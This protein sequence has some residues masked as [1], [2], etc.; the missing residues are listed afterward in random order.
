MNIN[1]RI[2]YFDKVKIYSI[3]ATSRSGSDYL[4]SLFDD[5]PQ[6]L[7]FNGSLPLYSQF[8]NKI[9]F[10]D[11]SNKNIKLTIT[12]FI[13][14]FFFLLNTKFDKEEGKNTLGEKK[15]KSIQIS[16]HKF[17]KILFYFINKKSFTKKNFYLGI[18]FA[19][20]VCIH[21]NFS[22]IKVLL[23]HPH[24]LEE[25]KLFK[26]DFKDCFYLVTIRH[27]VA[28]YYSTIYNLS[29]HNPKKFSNIKHSFI[30]F[31]R[32]F[33]DSDIFEKYKLKY[34]CIRLEDLPH[35]KTINA[36]CKIMK[37]KFSVKL[38]KPTFAGLKWNG[39]KKQTRDYNDKWSKDRTYNFWREK[40]SPRDQFFLNFFFYK[41][42]KHY[43]YSFYKLN[44]K[45]IF[46]F[47]FL[48]LMPT[49]FEK[50]FLNLK[51]F[52]LNI[53][54]KN[55]IKK[56]IEFLYDYT[57]YFRRILVC[58]SIYLKFFTKHKNKFLFIK[59]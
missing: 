23:L 42:L 29:K 51:Y 26:N 10:E 12:K 7:T 22:K 46:S 55:T 50:K 9:N 5:H 56:K 31:Y 57:F 40:L 33:T 4:Q 15:N 6:V 37:I 48:S 2:N 43:K 25:V 30:T 58:W 38:L 24:N 27:H 11:N 35:K 47:F 32:C 36:I 53:K 49:S 28:A 21:R 54:K 44:Y 41:K 3:I 20:N 19:Y 34:L 16:A 1:T 59:I 39:D 17:S 14:S 8:L 45:Y 52:L 18:Y 13:N